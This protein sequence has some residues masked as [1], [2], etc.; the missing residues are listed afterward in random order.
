[1]PVPSLD[2]RAAGF[3]GLCL[4][5]ACC[6]TVSASADASLRA[7][8]LHGDFAGAE[9][10]IEAHRAAGDSDP[11]YLSESAL[12]L[13]QMGRFSSAAE[14]YLASFKAAAAEPARQLECKLGE[15][16]CRKAALD[17]GWVGAAQSDITERLAATA[18][19]KGPAR[20]FALELQSALA[21]AQDGLWKTSEE[22]RKN[23][24][25]S[26]VVLRD[27]KARC[28]RL[29]R[30]GDPQK[31]AGAARQLLA[32]YPGCYWRH[33]AYRLWLYSCWVRQDRET[34]KAVGGKYL[35]E[36]PESPEAQG[37]VSRYYFDADMEAEA[38]LA[39]AQKSAALYEKQIGIDGGIG[40][41]LS[42]RDSLRPAVQPDYL[43][44]DARARYL[45]YLGSRFN[46]ARYWLRLRKYDAAL[47]QVKPVIEATPYT[48]EDAQGLAPFYCIA[49]QASEGAKSP[50][51]AYRY[52]L[53]CLIDG[54]AQGRYALIAQGRVN[55][56]NSV[57][58][59]DIQ[60]KL[61]GEALPAALG[62]MV[63][64]RLTDLGPAAGFGDRACTR[65]AWG[66]VDSDGAEDLLLDGGRLYFNRGPAGFNEAGRDWGLPS[67]MSGGVFADYD[68]DGDLDLA[69]F[70]GG[71]NT[72]RLLRND[73]SG[74]ADVGAV[75]GLSAPSQPACGACWTDLNADGW[76]DLAV[77]GQSQR[78]N[79]ASGSGYV[80]LF[81]SDAGRLGLPESLLPGGAPPVSALTAADC[82]HG[83]SLFCSTRGWAED[84]LL[85]PDGA[86]YANFAR[87]LGVAGSFS[88][89]AWGDTLSAA[90]GDVNGDG[91]ADLYACKFVDSADN[92]HYPPS[93]LLLAAEGGYGD[94]RGAWGIR[95][96][97][98]QVCPCFG[99]FNND[100]LLDLFISS[101][102]ESRSSWLYLNTGS[103]FVDTGYLAGC[104]IPGAQGCASADYDNDGD[105]DLAVCTRDGLHLLRNDT[106]PQFWLQVD[107]S[108]SPPGAGVFSN[109]RAIGAVVTLQMGALTMR[110][111]ICSGSGLACG[112]SL[113]AHFGLGAKEGVCTLTVRF[114]SGR[115]FSR[116]LRTGSQ[117]LQVS[118]D[119]GLNSPAS[120]P[121]R[122]DSP[123][124]TAP[125]QPPAESGPQRPGGS[126]RQP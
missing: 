13:E 102:S 29:G 38:G 126:S 36:Y 14:A 4:S 75:S 8:W 76:I 55:A 124:R 108:G 70:G 104:A 91:Q 2:R 20:Q 101:A 41:L 118:E 43:P 85:G 42:L 95:A 99:D 37:A 44:P 46:L 74:L 114:P 83:P 116:A 6:L 1:M 125:S 7:L 80:A 119:N 49:G 98:A 67:G 110:R 35:A 27:L 112:D 5:A 77:C 73:G 103:G 122:A 11:A 64:P 58:S 59:G 60:S 72:L 21:F 48:T 56:L 39:A 66:D 26:V 107:C 92:Y 53:R 25:D 52:F 121:P 47:A 71:R 78:L 23:Y 30:E 50:Q 17:A 82:G 19:Q 68:N 100:G 117:R 61:L 16:R 115:E 79:A 93:Q 12:A 54:G 81:I 120:E 105:L 96:D 51:A 111:D 97:S 62:G 32:D 28:D 87:L 10:Y 63:L 86:G 3:A 89:G 84:F 65:A 24:P 15:W 45:D 69:A 22:L 109:R 88:D 33:M 94:A 90:A 40:G 9:A 18:G 31:R 57:L 106:P 34:L 123:P 113:R